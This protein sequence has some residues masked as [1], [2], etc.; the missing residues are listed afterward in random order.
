[1]DIPKE[2]NLNEF[3]LNIKTTTK[4]INNPKFLNNVLSFGVSKVMELKVI[5]EAEIYLNNLKETDNFEEFTI[6]DGSIFPD[7]TIIPF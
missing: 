5:G 7:D 2:L 4:F 6:F 1:M 3:D